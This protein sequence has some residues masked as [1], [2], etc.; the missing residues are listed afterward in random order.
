MLRNMRW[1]AQDCTFGFVFSWRYSDVCDR[2]T[3]ETLLIA[4]ILVEVT[5]WKFIRDFGC[6]TIVKFN[7]LSDNFVLVCRG[8]CSGWGI[9]PS[10]I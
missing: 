2:H 3:P 6:S 5:M 9:V 1:V 4:T 10:S 8:R 7:K